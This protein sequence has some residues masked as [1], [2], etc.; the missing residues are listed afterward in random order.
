MMRRLV[1]RAFRFARSVRSGRFPG[2]GISNRGRLRGRITGLNGY[3]ARVVLVALL[4]ATP[5]VVAG[6]G[7]PAAIEESQ[8]SL[9]G[10]PGGTVS[11]A[12]STGGLPAT[13]GRTTTRQTASTVTVSF[14][15]IPGSGPTHDGLSLTTDYEPAYGIE[16]LPPSDEVT[17]GATVVECGPGDPACEA[18][19]DG[20]SVVAGAVRSEFA[21]H[22]ITVEFDEPQ[23]T[24]SLHLKHKPTGRDFTAIGTLTA[25][26]AEGNQLETNDVT[27]EPGTGWHPLEVGN[28]FG[29]ARI[30]EVTVA[31][32]EEGDVPYNNAIIVD[33]LS[34]RTGTSST[35]TPDTTPPDA[36]LFEPTNGSIVTYEEA[37]TGVALELAVSDDRQLANVSYRYRTD[38]W[39]DRRFICGNEHSRSCPPA[40]PGLDTRREGSVEPTANVPV[41]DGTYRIEV[42]GCD[43]AGNCATADTQIQVT[44]PGPVRIEGVNPESPAEPVAVRER[45]RRMAAGDNVTL[46]GSFHG[47]IDVALFADG[48]TSFP[49]ECPYRDDIPDS[50]VS[51]SV[52]GETLTVEMPAVPEPYDRRELFFGVYDQINGDGI[53]TTA[54]GWRR[55]E[56]FSLGEPS[57]PAAYSYQFE[58]ENGL[59]GWK[60]MQGTYGR[61][62]FVCGPGGRA[63]VPRPMYAAIWL[64]VYK[65]W[66]EKSSGS[67]VGMA[68]TSQLMYQDGESL[69]MIGQPN[70]LEASDLDENASYP[71]GIEGQAGAD[72]RVPPW[73]SR[74]GTEHFH[75]GSGPFNQFPRR[76]ATTWGVIR[77]SHGVQTSWEFQEEFLD[78]RLSDLNPSPTETLRE[79]RGNPTDYVLCMKKGN[80]G[81]CVSPYAVEDVNATTS[82]ILVYDN[83]FPQDM[84]GSDSDGDG[85]G[86]NW[87]YAGPRFVEVD[88]E[89]DTFRFPRSDT[90]DPSDPRYFDW[91]SSQ[92]FVY[93]VPTSV[94]ESGRHAPIDPA[95]AGDVGRSATSTS[96]NLVFGGADATYETDDGRWGWRSDGSFV[97]TMS[98]EATLAP[99]GQPSADNRFVPLHL[100][101]DAG[102][103]VAEVNVRGDNYTYHTSQP[104]RAFQLSV[105]DANAG[106]RDEVTPT[107]DGDNLQSV[108]LTPGSDRTVTA[109]VGMGFDEQSETVLTL[110][111]ADIGANGSAR[112]EALHDR[113]GIRFVNDG[114]EPSTHIL[115]VQ[116]VTMRGGNVTNASAVF[117]PFDVPAGAT[118]T[119]TLNDWPDAGTVSSE[120]DADNEGEDRR[121]RSVSGTECAAGPNAADADGDGIADSCEPGDQAVPESPAATAM[122]EEPTESPIATPYVVGVALAGLVLLATVVWRRRR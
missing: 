67:C 81:H 14:E 97:D 2:T 10:D 31:G 82:R 1:G 53:R 18:A 28:E 70:D 16:F 54:E 37:R 105:S 30:A 95:V 72:S 118:Q 66:M 73:G 61:N 51:R 56:I 76:P 110:A 109:R 19:H 24:V 4:V 96:L 43:L 40:D 35:P 77:A 52:D 106:E 21:S 104:G 12:P 80:G 8:S 91:N 107:F 5:S 115:L 63:C 75:T 15:E 99:L 29:S 83:N 102:A 101:V 100:P 65:R 58:N 64:P 89:D 59:S 39:S 98:R 11:A 113:R 68:A 60:P 62:A 27:F 117:G 87:S 3:S 41:A 85:L 121:E 47:R 93:A 86:D 44:T 50:N 32:G 22:P 7:S 13:D 90:T 17:G 25:Y 38:A 120:I 57:Y 74:S 114:E 108:G 84:S 119:I 55:S 122:G 112:F 34:F 88:T 79:V 26:D 20:Q 33:S 49:T 46:T 78:A 111:G 94:W 9:A 42:R 48:C 71:A 36:R 116:T 6:V 103:P 45:P 23:R 92:G 69:D